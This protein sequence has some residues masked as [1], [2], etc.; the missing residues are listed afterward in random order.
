MGI[1]G[2]GRLSP[3]ASPTQRGFVHSA[4]E[5]FV[6]TN[7]RSLLCSDRSFPDIC[8]SVP[9]IFGDY[10]KLSRED[11]K[12]VTCRGRKKKPI[13]SDE[14]SYVIR[15]RKQYPI[16]LSFRSEQEERCSSPVPIEIVVKT[17]DTLTGII[18]KKAPSPQGIRTRSVQINPV[19]EKSF[20]PLKSPKSEARSSPPIEVV[21]MLKKAVQIDLQEDIS[22]SQISNG[23]KSAQDTPEDFMSTPTRRAVTL[24][25]PQL[26]NEDQKIRSHS[27]PARVPPLISLGS[28]VAD[29]P[30][31]PVPPDEEAPPASAWYSQRIRTGSGEFIY[32][33]PRP[34]PTPPHSPSMKAGR[35]SPR[36]VSRSASPFL[37]TSPFLSVCM[38]SASDKISRFSRIIEDKKILFRVSLLKNLAACFC[39]PLIICSVSIVV[40]NFIFLPL[41]ILPSVIIGAAIGMGYF[42]VRSIF[43]Y[44]NYRRSINLDKILLSQAVIELEKELA[45]PR[46]SQDC[47]AAANIIF[48]VTPTGQ[49]TSN[50][51]TRL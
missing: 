43:G 18:K 24:P 38:S 45:K 7:P 19:E 5:T 13:P 40:A 21:R 4:D 22:C 28:P 49:S 2:T 42:L 26:V 17:S 15:M 29:A 50:C 35:A 36:V 10:P 37:S 14:L 27:S 9:A 8:S 32:T 23:L 25:A 39:V 44:F 31:V 12:R 20:P 48:P 34:V 3:M 51:V 6:D 47:L 46:P 1:I 16:R 33:Q 41:I 30:E 11:I